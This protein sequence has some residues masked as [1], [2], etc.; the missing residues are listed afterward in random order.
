MEKDE[1]SIRLGI[2]V[3]NIMHTYIHPSL[4]NIFWSKLHVLWLLLGSYF[5]QWTDIRYLNK[6]VQ[7][8]SNFLVCCGISIWPVNG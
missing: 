4:K 2:S 3:V 6:E 7:S 1:W 8:N 5:I